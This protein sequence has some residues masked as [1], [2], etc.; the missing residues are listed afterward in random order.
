MVVDKMFGRRIERKVEMGRRIDRMWPRT[1]VGSESWRVRTLA[2]I[3]IA[4]KRRVI[5]KSE[6]IRCLVK[7]IAGR[8]Y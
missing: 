5:W 6:M 1:G 2:W 8:R 3:E 7:G 4:V